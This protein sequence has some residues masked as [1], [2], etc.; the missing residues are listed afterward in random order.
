MRFTVITDSKGEI[1]AT[2]RGHASKDN[3]QAGL[4]AGPNQTLHEI[5]VPDEFGDITEPGE[6]H[7]RVK[8]HMQKKS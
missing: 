2:H 4:R 7:A 5:E 3:L 1:I 6:L 8:S